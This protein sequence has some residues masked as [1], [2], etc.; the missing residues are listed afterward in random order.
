VRNLLP[1]I[2][3]KAYKGFYD[4]ARYNDILGPKTTLMIHMAS[5]MAFGCYP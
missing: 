3:K 1:D 4:S 5:A 2:Q